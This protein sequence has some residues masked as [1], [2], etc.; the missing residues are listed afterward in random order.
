MLPVKVTAVPDILATTLSSLA[1]LKLK[2]VY[3]TLSPTCISLLAE[4]KVILLLLAA[5]VQPFT[6]ATVKVVL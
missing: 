1:V 4:P 2:P 3:E 5:T 6:V